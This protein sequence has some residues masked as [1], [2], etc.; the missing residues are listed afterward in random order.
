MPIN[1]EIRQLIDHRA[2][3]DDIRNM[4]VK[5][6]MTTLLEA[7]SKLAIEGITSLD[8]V[9]RVGYTLD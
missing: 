1:E 2:N 8:E 9:L 3:I 7:A 6:G 5:E 4:A